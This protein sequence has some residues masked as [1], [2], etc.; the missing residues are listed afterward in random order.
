MCIISFFFYLREQFC[1]LNH[2]NTNS[3][4]DPASQPGIFQ[5][6]GPPIIRKRI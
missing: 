4:Y 5:G 6:E 2:T 3:N 1:I